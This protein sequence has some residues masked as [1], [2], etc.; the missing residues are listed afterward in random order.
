MKNDARKKVKQKKI[1][2]MFVG[3]FVRKMKREKDFK[4]NFTMSLKKKIFSHTKNVFYSNK[5]Q[6]TVKKKKAKQVRKIVGKT[7][8]FLWYIKNKTVKHEKHVF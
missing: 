5:K 1:E 3:F 8:S 6:R 7:T 2:K 4:R